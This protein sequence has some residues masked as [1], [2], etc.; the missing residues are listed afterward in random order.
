MRNEFQTLSP[1]LANECGIFNLNDSSQGGSH[2]CAWATK[3]GRYYFF[4]SFGSSPCKE[5][6]DYAGDKSILYHD[7]KIQDFED[8]NCGEF[9]ILFLFL[10]TKLSTHR[11]SDVHYA[12]VVRFLTD[13]AK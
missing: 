1:P 6:E 5:L 11:N 3:G 8:S 10:F 12:N 2:W 9:C 7:Y 13:F 4:C